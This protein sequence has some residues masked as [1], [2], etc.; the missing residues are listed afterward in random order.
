MQCARCQGSTISEVFVD[1][2][3]GAGALS[4][5]GWRCLL[6][7]DITDAV[8]L[9]NRTAR[10]QPSARHPRLST[11]TTVQRDHRQSWTRT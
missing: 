6:C 10:P 3:S 2:E 4:F 7:G 5:P 9:S 1:W 8:I 11:V